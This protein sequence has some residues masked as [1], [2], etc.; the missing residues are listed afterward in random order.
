SATCTT[1]TC[2]EKFDAELSHHPT[3]ERAG[4]IAGYSNN[5]LY[6]RAL[7]NAISDVWHYTPGSR[8]LFSLH[9]VPLEDIKAGDTYIAEAELALGKVADLLGLAPEDWAIAYHSRFEDSRKWASP[10]PK[11]VLA[12]WAAE[13]ITRVA[14]VTPGFAADCLESLYDIAQV[15]KEYFEGLCVARGAQGEVTYIPA[16]NARADHIDL[17]FDLI[18][19]ALQ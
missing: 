4:S 7:A 18:T 15:A 19:K 8:L 9:S 13:G 5:P 3:L 2:L 16:L 10:H 11:T 6:W 17:L 12:Q 14:L 1:H